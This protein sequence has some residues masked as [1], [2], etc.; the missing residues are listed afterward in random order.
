MRLP[1]VLTLLCAIAAFPLSAQRELRVQNKKKAKEI[2]TQTL[3]TAKDLPSS[4]VGETAHMGFWVT[5]LLSKGLLSQQVRDSLRALSSRT[6]APV[7]HIRAFTA[8]T[9]DVRRVRDLVSDYYTERRQPLPSLSLVQAGGLPLEGA[10]VVLEAIT[11]E[12]KELNPHGLALISPSLVASRDPLEPIAPLAARSLDALR[13][14]LEVAGV[15]PADVLRVTCFLTSLDNVSATRQL[16]AQAYPQASADY[17]QTQR[18]PSQAVAGC[19]AVARLRA[20][21]GAPLRF[22]GGTGTSDTD[23][24]APV[25]LVGA[26]RLLLTGSQIAFGYR[27][28]DARLAFDRLSKELEQAG[29][30]PREVAVARFYSLSSALSGEIRKL[31][32]EFFGE[33]SMPAG[34]LLLLEGLPALEAGFAVDLVAVKPDPSPR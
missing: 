9:G 21:P 28:Q 2:P 7:L 27:D 23:N 13:R 15:T 10:Q 22:A 19:E 25:A 33:G 24:M 12:K 16:V 30:S 29:I 14:N 26:S 4:V 1:A 5:P 18:A 6:G 17:I 31:R 20:D 11:A 8:G 32:G 3:E 34:A